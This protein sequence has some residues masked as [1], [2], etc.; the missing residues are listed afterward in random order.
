MLQIK[1]NTEGGLVLR[2]KLGLK[3]MGCWLDPYIVSFK[4]PEVTAF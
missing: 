4:Q 3:V 1:K 2:L